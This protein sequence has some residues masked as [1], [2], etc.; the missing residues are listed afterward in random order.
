MNHFKDILKQV[1]EL[2]T[3]LDSRV[4]G[5]DETIISICKNVSF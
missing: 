5:N 2:L 4:H 1:V 3:P